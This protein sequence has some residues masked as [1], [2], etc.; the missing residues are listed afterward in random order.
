M[1]TRMCYD[2]YP[3]DAHEWDM[4]VSHPVFA[5]GVSSRDIV[6]ISHEKITCW[7]PGHYELPVVILATDRR[8]GEKWARTVGIVNYIVVTSERDLQGLR[9][10]GIVVTPGYFDRAI[11]YMLAY[12]K[13]FD[14]AK[15]SLFASSNTPPELG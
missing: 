6:E 4:N 9:I 13:L 11:G 10:R 12:T 8:A 5:D 15:H 7:C 1:D 2:A 14:V 3:H